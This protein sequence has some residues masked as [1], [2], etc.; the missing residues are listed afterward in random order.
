MTTDKDFKKLVRARMAKTGESYMTA[1]ENM[2][3]KD[4]A[5]SQ[6]VE[7]LGIRVIH[8]SSGLWA[9]RIRGN[10]ELV[11]HGKTK[12]EAQHLMLEE[13]WRTESDWRNQVDDENISYIELQED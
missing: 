6:E 2:L 11:T 10:S 8:E 3:R 12:E 9:A 13:V 4:D 1:R 7:A 5:L